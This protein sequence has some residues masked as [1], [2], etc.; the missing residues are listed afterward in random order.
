MGFVPAELLGHREVWHNG[1]TPGA[2]GYTYNA[3]F[4]DDQLAVIVLSNGSAFRGEPEKMVERTL[5]AFFPDIPAK[6]KVVD[7]PADN[8]LARLLFSQFQSGVVDR[9]KLS[10]DFSKA[11]TPALIEQLRPQIAPLGPPTELSL[12]ERTTATQGTKCSYLA[13]FGSV[14]L[15]LRMFVTPDGRVAGFGISP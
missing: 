2:G 9:T 12:E 7:N 6:A 8:A 10:E 3:I 11:L 5:R 14:K 13:T 1:L 4:P 15:H